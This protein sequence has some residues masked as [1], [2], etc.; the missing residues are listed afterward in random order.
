[1]QYLTGLEQQAHQSL[2]RRLA[3]TIPGNASTEGWAHYVEQ[4]VVEQGL[5]PW[6]VE[7][8]VEVDED[9]LRFG[10]ISNALLRTGRLI[11]ALGM[12]LEHSEFDTRAKAKAYMLNHCFQADALADY[13][14]TSASYLGVYNMNYTF[15]KMMILKLRGDYETA[16]KSKLGPEWRMTFHNEVLA[17][18][19]MP[20]KVVRQELLEEAKDLKFDDMMPAD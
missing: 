7:Q 2:A 3:W 15:G 13:E 14:A 12:Q 18:G 4:M 8:G 20:L 11:V 17:A 6:M 5:G 19:Q 16:N 10:Q 9:F 1:M